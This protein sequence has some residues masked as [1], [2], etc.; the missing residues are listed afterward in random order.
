MIDIFVIISTKYIICFHNYDCVTC[1]V[2]NLELANHIENVSVKDV[3][4]SL[5]TGA[6]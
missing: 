3:L 6:G 1:N 4:L 2:L 5:S